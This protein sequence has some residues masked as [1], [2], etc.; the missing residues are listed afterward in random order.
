MA[1]LLSLIWSTQFSS[2]IPGTLWHRS[3][4]FL[5]ENKINFDKKSVNINI[6][7][8][9]QCS[10][11]NPHGHWQNL[12]EMHLPPFKQLHE[13]FAIFDASQNSPK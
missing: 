2:Q 3:I 5:K 4:L 13:L 8:T 9:S 1:P 10:P 6:N 12:P 7:S 11:M